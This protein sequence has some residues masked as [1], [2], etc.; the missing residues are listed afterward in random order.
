MIFHELATN[1]CK[2]GSL[3]NAAGRVGITWSVDVHEST[4]A[5]SLNW[6]ESGGPLVK[7]ADRV[8]F[9]SKLINRLARSLPGGRLSADYQPEGL[10]FSLTFA[11]EANGDSPV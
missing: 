1:A 10:Q 6:R 4:I 2:Y 5:V 11:I 8:G 3:S 7:P 9:G